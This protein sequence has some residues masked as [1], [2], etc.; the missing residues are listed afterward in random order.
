[1][2]DGA[3]VTPN[4]QLAREA[5]ERPHV[6]LTAKTL[7]FDKMLVMF[8]TVRLVLVMVT[9][10]AALVEPTAWGSNVK[11]G[12]VNVI[13]LVDVMLLLTGLAAA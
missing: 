10:L 3:K 11:V 7:L 12:G 9:D 13:V 1:M 2:L 8:S 5:T 4:V 6:L